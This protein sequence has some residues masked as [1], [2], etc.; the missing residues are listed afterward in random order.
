MFKQITNLNGD[1]IYLITSLWIFLVFFVL[2]GCMLFWMK[3][4]HVDYMKDIPFDGSEKESEHASEQ[5][6]RL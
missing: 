3:K 2:V 6:E 4:D 5:N 1:E